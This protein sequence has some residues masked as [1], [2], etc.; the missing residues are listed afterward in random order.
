LLALLALPLVGYQWGV[1]RQEAEQLRAELR[2]QSLQA[3]ALSRA[4]SGLKAWAAAVAEVAPTR[5]RLQVLGETPSQWQSQSITLEN[6]AM[7]RREAELYLRDLQNTG[8]R[9]LVLSAFHLRPAVAGE[10]VFV[11]NQGLDRAGALALTLK[12]ELFT[13]KL[14]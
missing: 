5:D 12:A 2:R 3:P 10:S 6:Q 8:D 9:M 11:A 14:P 7:S 13:R 4:E 1:A